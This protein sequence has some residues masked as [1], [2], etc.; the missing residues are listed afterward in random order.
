MYNILLSGA[1]LKNG[2]PKK[3]LIK[4]R[5]KKKPHILQYLP[6]NSRP[7]SGRLREAACPTQAQTGLTAG[8]GADTSRC[9]GSRQQ[10][11]LPQLST[12]CLIL[13]LFASFHGTERLQNKL[14]TKTIRVH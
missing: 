10:Q 7:V 12:E 14:K 1:Q 6:F 2:Y 13:V 9:Y 8:G 5:K 4:E 3:K 11:L